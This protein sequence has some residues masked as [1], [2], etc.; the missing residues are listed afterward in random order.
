MPDVSL[1][2]AAVHA[3][4][5]CSHM[6]VHLAHNS[7]ESQSVS[8]I[9][10][11][12]ALRRDCRERPDI[13]VELSGVSYSSHD[14]GDRRQMFLSVLVPGSWC[15]ANSSNSQTVGLLVRENRVKMYGSFATNPHSQVGRWITAMPRPR[16]M[17]FP[18][19]K[20]K[21][22]TRGPTLVRCLRR[23]KNSC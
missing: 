16:S 19:Y 15:S 10:E 11:H 22:R 20:S 14:R 23:R 2:R 17:F 7:V 8:R 21:T 13:R 9:L 5:S 12:L 1:F 6:L 3:F 4:C 18:H